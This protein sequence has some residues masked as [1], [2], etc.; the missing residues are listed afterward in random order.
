[1]GRIYAG[2]YNALRKGR[3]PMIAEITATVENGILKP[4]GALPFPDQTRVKLTI[5][6]VATKDTS[7]AGWQALLAKFDE[8][9]I[10]GDGKPYHRDEL[11]ERD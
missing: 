4:D 8:H 3:W 5:E 9:P 2:W 6:P 1:M 11:Y 7:W 10:V